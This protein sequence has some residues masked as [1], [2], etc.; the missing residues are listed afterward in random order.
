MT[1]QFGGREPDWSLGRFRDLIMKKQFLMSFW[2][3]CANWIKTLIGGDLWTIVKKN[4]VIESFVTAIFQDEQEQAKKFK[5]SA[6]IDWENIMMRKL[7]QF[8]VP[9]FNI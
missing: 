1:G 2:W 5:S 3:I 7:K 6:G 4:A 8:M 9:E